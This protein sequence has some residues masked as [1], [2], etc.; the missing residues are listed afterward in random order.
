MPYNMPGIHIVVQSDR[1]KIVGIP[2]ASTEVVSEV[3]FASW[4]YARG[5]ICHYNCNDTGSSLVDTTGNYP[6]GIIGSNVT[7]GIITING[8][9]IKNI[10]GTGEVGD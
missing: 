1:T 5:C 3:T 9:G 4:A 6:P 8:T 7:K 10:S 2:E